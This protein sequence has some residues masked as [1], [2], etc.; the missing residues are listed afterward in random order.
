[1]KVTFHGLKESVGVV[2]GREDGHVLG[3]GGGGFL[4]ARLDLVL[5]E[6]VCVEDSERVDESDDELLAAEEGKRESACDDGAW[7]SWL[8]DVGIA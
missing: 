6:L 8:L 5:D 3:V 1:M 7:V 4:D 2:G